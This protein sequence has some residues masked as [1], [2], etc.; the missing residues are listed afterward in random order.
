M[1]TH[2]FTMS[3]RYSAKSGC[4]AG[5]HKRASYKS[6]TGKYVPTRCVCAT[7]TY[8]ESSK[9]FKRAQA[10]R[11]SR[12]MTRKGLRSTSRGCPPGYISRKAYIRKYSSG[13]RSRGY[14]VKRA[15]GTTYRVFPSSKATAVKS[16]CIKDLGLPGKGPRTGTGIGPLRK[17]ELAKHGYAHSKTI[18][19]RHSALKKAAQEFGALGVYRKLDAVAKLMVRTVPSA[20]R[21]FKAD[22]NWV[23]KTMGPLKA[24]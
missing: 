14:G 17:G 22:R 5:Y 23:K 21:T 11:M 24:F 13:L 9:E 4:P 2:R 15:S 3:K 1:P 16:K 18:S 19:A 12:R 8:K 6:S 10:L 20:A 7:T